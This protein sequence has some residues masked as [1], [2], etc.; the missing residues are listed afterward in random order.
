MRRQSMVRSRFVTVECGT[1]TLCGGQVVARQVGSWSG[2]L[3]SAKV[4][5]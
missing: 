2:S 3:S 4:M 1:V 5:V